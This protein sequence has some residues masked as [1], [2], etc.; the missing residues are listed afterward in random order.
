[1]ERPTWSPST[2]IQPI[3]FS[4]FRVPVNQKEIASNPVFHRLGHAQYGVGCDRGVHSRPASGQNLRSRL[5][6]QG[7][8]GRHNTAFVDDHGAAIGSILRRQCRRGNDQE[9]EQTES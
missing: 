9:A 7:V 1:M 2:R 5:R 8:A 3:Q 4:G 6:S